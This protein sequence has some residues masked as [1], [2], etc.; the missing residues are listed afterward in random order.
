MVAIDML[1]YKRKLKRPYVRQ[2]FHSGRGSDT[3]SQKLATKKVLANAI[4]SRKE[5]YVAY[6]GKEYTLNEF[7]RKFPQFFK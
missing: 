7:I 1:Q 5:L 6:R 2:W 3:Y 4:K